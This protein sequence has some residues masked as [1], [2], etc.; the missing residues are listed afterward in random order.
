MIKSVTVYTPNPSFSGYRNAGRHS[1][2]FR[3]GRAKVDL[4][5][6]KIF[7]INYGYWCPEI[8]PDHR[9]LVEQNYG[10]RSSGNPVEVTIVAKPKDGKVMVRFLQ[11]HKIGK[12]LCSIGDE[13]E[14][15]A[16]Y[17]NR[18]AREGKVEILGAEESASPDATGA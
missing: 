7:V 9:E 15:K 18:L 6:A 1:T 2:Q 4:D 10:L 11:E 14:L 12:N 17:A 13:K 8:E 5:T 16:D 3:K